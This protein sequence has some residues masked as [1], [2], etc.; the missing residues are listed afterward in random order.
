MH[1]TSDTGF[2]LTVCK[3]E[4]SFA[5]RPDNGHDV[6]CNSIPEIKPCGDVHDMQV[7]IFG[8]NPASISLDGEA[9]DFVY[10]DNAAVFTL[11]AELHK[12]GDV[13]YTITK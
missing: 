2:S 5:G 1:N 9:I 10:E 8:T 11:P 4:G 6:S 7:K 3:R 13:V 12:A